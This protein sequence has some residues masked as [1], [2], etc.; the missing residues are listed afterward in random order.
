MR[1]GTT[2][3]LIGVSGCLACG[4]SHALTAGEY[5]ARATRIC[6][7]GRGTHDA[8]PR[9]REFARLRAPAALA[10]G[11]RAVVHLQ[12]RRLT[13]DRRE[14]EVALDVVSNGATSS[15]R[16]RRFALETDS[17]R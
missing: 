17:L 13:A 12:R 14:A 10:G 4:G 16:Y 5:R 9:W 11:H 15:P 1:R 2:C 7:D 6:T 3:L 8:R